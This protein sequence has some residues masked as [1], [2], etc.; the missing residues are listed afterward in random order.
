M[1]VRSRAKVKWAWVIGLLAVCLVAGV[2]TRSD[3]VAGAA[4]VLL[5][6]VQ[7]GAAR[8]GGSAGGLWHALANLRSLAAENTRLRA[9]LERCRLRAVDA[10]EAEQRASRLAE[11]V[12]LQ[13]TAQTRSLAA[14]VIA[15][16]PSVWFRTVTLN[17]GSR[18]GVAPGCAVLAPG[19]MLGQVYRAGPNSA[20]AVCLSD[21]LG[22]VGARL[23]PARARHVLGVARGDGAGLCTLVC[24]DPQA[25]VRPG[26]PVVTSGFAHGSGFPPGLL[27][28]R[29]LKVERRPDESS[30]VAII[31]PAAEPER[32]EEVL[33]LLPASDEPGGAP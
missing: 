22:S 6:P 15:L 3:P 18:H 14:R 20:Q 31:R 29:V 33:V 4:S 32:A 19:G 17:V 9:E 25:D 30:L 12:D 5:R 10:G 2:R 11:L 27:I 13:R 7:A 28:G 26:D 24:G 16:S 8:L 21:R 1:A 23:Q